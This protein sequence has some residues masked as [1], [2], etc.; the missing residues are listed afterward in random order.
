MT[1]QMALPLDQGFWLADGP[2][3]V[4]YGMGVD[5]TAML[6]GMVKRG[7]RPDLVTFADT[8]G[9]KP[10]T[11][12][13]LPIINDYLRANGFP[14]VTVVRYTPRRFKNAPYSTLEGNCLSNSTLPSISFRFRKSCSLKWKAA[15]QENYI[16]RHWQPG[17]DQVERGKPIRRLIGYDAGPKDSRRGAV[18][19]S[20]LFWYACPLQ[21]WGWD[22]AYCARVIER[23]GLPVPPKSA[24]FFCASSHES[25]VLEL[26]RSHPR[27]ARRAIE[28]E[29]QAAPKLHTI[30][31]L[32]PDQPWESYL[33]EHLTGAERKRVF[34][35][36]AAK[37]ELP[38][39]LPDPVRVEIFPYLEVWHYA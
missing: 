18:T 7:I 22:R 28:M 34:C 31:G 12:A 32:W 20:E 13:Y 9:E 11:Y 21:Q 2:L 35:G 27:L 33:R 5:S 1:G 29:R 38:T 37:G 4:A 6:I 36:P 25:E 19:P 10:E 15:P 16:T 39:G 17:V 14:L 3:T 24:C 30:A 23:E 8:G 26:A